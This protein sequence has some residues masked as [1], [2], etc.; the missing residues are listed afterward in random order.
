MKN[1]S[2]L[3]KIIAIVFITLGF[4][5]TNGQITINNT[6]YTP[7]Q[8]IDG[9]LVPSG[10]GTTVS[11][12]A[13]QGV[14]NV[15][16][17]YQVGYFTTATTTLTQMGFTSGVVLSTGNT[18]DIPL[19]LGA[20]PR[21]AAQMSTGYTSTCSNGEIRQTGTC[22]V[23]I[24]D[25]DIL[26]GAYNY[27][28]ASILEFDFVP[29]TNFAKFRYIFGSE[30]YEDNSGIINYQC[31]AYNDKFGFLISGPGISGG[32]GYT[33]DARN[34][35]RLANGS[36]V[37]INSVNNGVVGSSGGAPAAA[38]CQAANAGWVQN[39]STAE[40]LGTIDG[41]ELNGNT[42]ILTAQQSGLTPGQ[43]YHI[44][45][46]VTDVSDG[47]YDAVVYLEAGSFVTSSS[48]NA[49]INQSI[50]S[51]SAN[52]NAISPASGSWSVVTGTGSFVNQNSPV[53]SVSGLALGANI[54]KWSNG[55]DSSTVTI[56]VSSPTNATAGSS[57]SLNCTTTSGTISVSSS[58]S[59]ATYSWSGTGIVSG[60]STSSPTVNA[61]GT[62]TVT[63]T[64]P[65]NGCTATASV[66][67]SNNTT[68][69]NLT[70][71]SP[72]AL[73][74]ITTSGTI[75]ASSTTNG[76]T[77]NWS[78]T[79]I[80]S[81]GSSTSP[82]VNAAGIYN[83]TVTNPANSC[84]ATAS[85]S[86]S[87]NTTP[88]N[89]TAGS[90]LA[91]NCITIS[92]IIS[93]SSTTNG[94]TYN[95][96][97]TGIVSGGSSA[98]PTVNTAGTYTVTVTNSAN[99]CTANTSVT[100][101]NNTTAPNVSIA[102]PAS[103]SCNVSSVTLTASS[104]TPNATYNWGNG[105]TSATYAVSSAGNYTTT[106]TDPAN[107]CTASASATVISGA[108]AV[109]F[110]YTTTNDTCGN[111]KGSASLNVL[112]GN[113]PFTYLW[114]NNN[115][116][117]AISNIL[118][119]TYTVTVSD[120][121]GCS[122][123]SLI[124]V[125]A[126]ATLSISASSTNT[127][128]GLENGMA[129]ANTITGNTP[130]TYLWSNNNT[131]DSLL[132]LQ[133]GTYQVTVSDASGCTATAS[134]IINSSSVNNVTVL[135]DTGFICSGDSAH[136]C[137]TSGFT[138]Y[139]WNTGVT[140]E[141]FYAKL[142]GN[143]YVTVT[144]INNCTAAS[145]HLPLQVY[146]LPPVSIS[147]N[148]DTLTAYNSYTY[149]WY[150]NSDIIS[151]AA[152]PVYIANQNGS[153]SVAVSD[154]NGCKAFSNPVVIVISGI[155]FMETAKGYKIFPN[156]ASENGTWN[157]EVAENLRGG[158]CEILDVE[159]KLIYSKTIDSNLTALQLSI[160]KGMYVLKIHSGETIHS[161]K[162]IKL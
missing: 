100:V 42:K 97:G 74:C 152:S 88:P 47:A 32:Q 14:Y 60:G 61:A 125:N 149:Q 86:V 37:S 6:V 29:V 133:E 92:G 159:G 102:S 64:N 89:L 130:F 110:T 41:T 70:A 62:Y 50:C 90:P 147:I 2:L 20:D 143:Y 7:T 45:L 107:G 132:N 67:V 49:G 96:S 17:K 30:E 1:F 39:V 66:G 120:V 5:Y 150:F 54:L 93:A 156:P 137:A 76:V 55:T 13:Y 83:V 153:Y 78:G 63:V 128:C 81:G 115:T 59:G 94:V 72:L 158:M 28:N 53:T 139:Q 122:A 112:S 15:S 91:L 98:S 136:I 31:S 9:V 57:L 36:E 157:L 101:T 8:L 85:V 22:P 104:T 52:L 46:I 154:T 79:G 16:N 10:G 155:D 33:N 146:P 95:W 87:N 127:T 18:A 44:K 161:F 117:S 118:A 160:S 3:K 21:A 77:Y 126:I 99:G 105:N 162:L 138:S 80:V 11:N 103:L 82:T 65:A 141:C 71:G 111:S 35:A 56:T 131:N 145:N 75:N 48:A 4:Y 58:T 84:T 144:D 148:G 108:G 124:T 135:S 38:K 51:N 40:Y 116:T 12:V 73:N 134:T 140:T 119:G 24:N 25:V 142:A 106:V 23:Y 68:P 19:T 69:P 109:S 113:A 114:N 34:I 151:G 123:T 26:A 27:Y 129:V 121:G 43:T